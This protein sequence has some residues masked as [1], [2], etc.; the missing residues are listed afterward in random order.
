MGQAHCGLPL[1]RGT[2]DIPGVL[3]LSF[4]FSTWG[5][6]SPKKRHWTARD[7]VEMHIRPIKA[8]QKG[9]VQTRDMHIRNGTCAFKD[10][11]PNRIE[12]KKQ[13]NDPKRY[14]IKTNVELL[15]HETHYPYPIHPSSNPSPSTNS[16]SSPPSPPSPPT[17]G[18]T[19]QSRTPPSSSPPPP[20]PHPSPPSQSPPSHPPT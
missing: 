2:H 16:P 4:F 20:H 1:A 5:A 13:R 8:S 18:P 11:S 19:P 12:K 3:F 15:I 7:V 9:V 10:D 17:R 6:R 14:A